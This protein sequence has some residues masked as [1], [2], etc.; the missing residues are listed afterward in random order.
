MQSVFERARSTLETRGTVTQGAVPESIADSWRRCLRVGLDPLARP[1]EAVVSRQDLLARKQRAARVLALTRPELELLSSQIAGT[2]YLVAFADPDGVVLDTIL[3]NEFRQ[4][5]AGRT[6]VEGSIWTE[7]VR[8]TNALG[9]TLH[10]GQSSMVTGPE[11]FFSGH[12]GVSCQS[13]PIFDSHERLVGLIDA[14][15][16]VAARQQHTGALVN[17]AAINVSN[18]LF[19]EDHRDQIIVLFHPRPEYLATQS[20]GMLAF[21]SEGRLS[22]GNQR[23]KAMLHGISLYDQTSFSRIFQESFGRVLHQF[24]DGDTIRLTD[25]MNSGVFARIRPTRPSPEGQNGLVRRTSLRLPALRIAPGVSA[26]DNPP[27]VFDDDVLRHHIRVSLRA[28]AAGMPVFFW[29][30]TGSGKTET[31]LAIHRELHAG[32][33]FVAVDCASL[34]AD[35]LIGQL[36]ADDAGAGSDERD[37]SLDLAGG[38][39]IY[40]DEVGDLSAQAAATVNNLV[41]KV[42]EMRQSTDT[43]RQWA[44]L[45]SSE[46]NL[47]RLVENRQL[48]ERLARRLAGYSFRMP[49][50]ADRT[51][52]GKLA[53]NIL[54]EIVPDATLAE[55]AV[56]RLRATDCLIGF[57][58]L[59]KLLLQI[60]THS[61]G[62]VIRDSDVD[63]ALAIPGTDPAPC[64]KCSGHP[65]R[66]A[67][68]LEIQRVLAE[69]DGR[70]SLAARRLGISRNTIYAHIVR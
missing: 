16:E 5:G 36:A 7:E 50:L 28:V 46:S 30:A 43:T 56:R 39:T 54:A 9:L 38:G 53:R 63:H 15:S 48:P 19:V 6:I 25:W 26:T 11:H 23:A 18:R 34:R 67:K 62:K 70:V 14:S 49:T 8:G 20:V 29:G 52:L 35:C 57:Y 22:G 12:G 47:D 58:E 44:V 27:R 13:A 65:I 64:A 51:D 10:S 45:C 2:N 1:I 59:K 32:K 68:C 42:K 24:L 4:S 31:A 17:L 55:S 40:L 33:T 61:Q 66:Q 69:C 37:K 21:D 41:S 3:D 60:G